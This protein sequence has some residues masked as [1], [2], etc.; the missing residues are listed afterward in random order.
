MT[1]LKKTIITACAAVSVFAAG[2]ACVLLPE[3]RGADA[4]TTDTVSAS[5]EASYWKQVPHISGWTWGNFSASENLFTAVPADYYIGYD[6]EFVFRSEGGSSNLL[7]VYAKA[8]AA[9]N[10]AYHTKDPEYGT[11]IPLTGANLEKY[12]NDTLGKWDVGNYTMTVSVDAIDSY[13]AF[14][15]SVTFAVQKA[16]NY[17]TETPHI[18]SWYVGEWLSASDFPPP[19]G[20]AAYGKVEFKVYGS[21]ADADDSNEI[22]YDSVYYTGTS[23]P[24]EIPDNRLNQAQAGRYFLVA[25]VSDSENYEALSAVVPFRVFTSEATLAELEEKKAAALDEAE[26]FAAEYSVNTSL[27]EIKAA[28]NRITNATSVSGV[29]VGLNATKVAIYRVHA[30]NR[31]TEYAEEL[32]ADISIDDPSLSV[33]IESINNAPDLATIDVNLH[34]ALEKIYGKGVENARKAATEELLA[35]A[36]Q[37]GV[38]AHDSFADASTFEEVAERLAKWKREISENAFQNNAGADLKAYKAAARE[39]IIKYAEYVGIEVDLGASDTQINLKLTEIELAATREE[40]DVIYAD[41]MKYISAELTAVKANLLIDL[42]EISEYY[43]DKYPLGRDAVSQ[44]LSPELQGPA[45]DEIYDAPTMVSARTAFDANE[46]KIKIAVLPFAKE[47]AKEDLKRAAEEAAIPGFS[48]EVQEYLQR[49]DGA[50]SVDEVEEILDAALFGIGNTLF[51]ARMR[52]MREFEAFAKE[53]FAE[54]NW[55]ALMEALEDGKEQIYNATAIADIYKAGDTAKVSFV[56]AYTVS[57]LD[58]YGE[59]YKMYNIADLIRARKAECQGVTTISRLNGI[60]ANAEET[61]CYTA[62]RVIPDLFETESGHYSKFDT[63]AAEA[64]VSKAETIEEVHAAF[65]AEIARLNVLKDAV[66]VARSMLELYAESYGLSINSEPVL[67]AIDIL[68]GAAS[69]DDLTELLITAKAEIDAVAGAEQNR[70]NS[71]NA[72]LIACTAVF[73]VSAAALAVL[74]VIMKKKKTAKNDAVQ[75][76]A[77]VTA[78]ETPDP[79]VAEKE[80]DKTETETETK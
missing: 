66:G 62:K 48:A 42:R 49:I 79:Q 34:S 28:M 16:K 19:A 24:D 60:L 80:E 76:D 14:Q 26:K 58:Y 12:L 36:A 55:N 51:S 7:T 41:A 47:K 65:T 73:A 11:P 77:E 46:E 52:M 75:T 15:S 20:K 1:K 56:R 72:A 27:G 54:Y 18:E 38:E 45:R 40:V 17:W 59:I 78:T 68:Y 31:I 23:D 30:K 74:L 22:D 39:S 21:K 37:F 3:G 63:S 13:P 69:P 70:V 9:G 10:L 44:I 50:N 2:A 4:A 33:E 64:A 43:C 8:D 71:V 67:K 53:Y 57:R 6:I 61:I 5:A 35:Y 29:R 25:S 32:N